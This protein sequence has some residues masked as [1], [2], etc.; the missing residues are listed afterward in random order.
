[1]TLKGA[2]VA[3]RL[4]MPVYESLPK[5]LLRVSGENAIREVYEGAVTTTD[6][7]H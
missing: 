1:M 5:L 3:R 4:G 2:I 6:A 7:D